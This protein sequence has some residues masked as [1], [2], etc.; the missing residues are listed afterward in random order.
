MKIKWL[1]RAFQN[2]E[3]IAN[4]LQQDNPEIAIQVILKIQ[5]GIEKL[6]DFPLMGRKGR[7]ASTRELVIINTPYVIIYRIK[8]NSVEILRILHSAQKFPP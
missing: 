2:L 1:K 5:T 3:N 7:V 4:Y 6:A 8:N